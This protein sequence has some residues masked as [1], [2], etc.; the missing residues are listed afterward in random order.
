MI[1]LV[2]QSQLKNMGINLNIKTLPNGWDK[3]L[4][5][6]YHLFLHH[7]GCLPSIPGGISIGD[8]YHSKGGWPYSYHSEK[9]DALI[10]SA[11]T[12]LDKTRMRQQC[13]EI[14]EVLHDANPCIPLYDIAKA[15]VMNKKVQGFRH[16]PTMFHMDITD[17]VIS[18]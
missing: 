7:S 1:A 2:V 16:G 8:K 17:L 6:E 14:W 10:E 12:T 15:V 9:L 3:R 13:D 4:T 11:F 18:E 5:G